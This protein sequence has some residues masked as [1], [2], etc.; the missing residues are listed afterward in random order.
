M[1]T[2]RLISRGF[3]LLGALS[4][5]NLLPAQTR[6]QSRACQDAVSQQYNAAADEITVDPGTVNNG[7]SVMTWRTRR[8]DRGYC[9]VSSRNQIVNLN[10]GDFR[11]GDR[12]GDNDRNGGSRFSEGDAISTCRNEAA[13]RLNADI[14][15]V[16]ANISENSGPDARVNWSSRGRR[17][18]CTVSRNLRVT[19]FREDA[20][21]SYTRNDRAN[22][23]DRSNSYG[24]DRNNS[25]GNRGVAFP[26]RITNRGGGGKCTFEVEVDGVAEVEI[27][28]DQGFLRNLS[29]SPATWRRL[30]CTQPFPRD[31][32][33]FRFQGVD[34]RGRQDLV[35]QPRGGSGAIIRIEDPKAGRE[36]YTGDIF[37]R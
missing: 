34:G 30:E 6:S 25:G 15:D 26:A 7:N 35:S 36:G 8:G 28:G 5:Q 33:E 14:R 21:G 20:G 19:D 11:G 3:I 13:R 27:I 18:S 1:R 17:G 16:D 37:W 31:A 22:E 32:R 4:L 12:G 29:G 9:E 2:E 24:R 10:R 23:N